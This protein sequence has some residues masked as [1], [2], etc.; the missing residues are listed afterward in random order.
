MAKKIIKKAKLRFGWAE[1]WKPT[2]AGIRRIA[3]AIVAATT[4]SGALTSLNG[5]E[6]VGTVIFVLGFVAKAV[7]NF[8]SK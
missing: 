6:I 2:P 8:F 5:H 3:D 4:F 1:Y 7:S